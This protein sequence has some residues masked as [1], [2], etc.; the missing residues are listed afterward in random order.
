MSCGSD[1]DN[2]EEVQSWDEKEGDE[3]AEEHSR[4][5]KRKTRIDN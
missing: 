4:P 5:S 3:Q 2:I 1:Y